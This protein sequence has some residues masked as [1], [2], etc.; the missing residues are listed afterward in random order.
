MPCSGAVTSFALD[1]L[2]SVLQ[3]T[4]SERLSQS[5][6][7]SGTPPSF[8]STFILASF[9]LY[10]TSHLPDII[11]YTICFLDVFPLES[12][13]YSYIPASVLTAM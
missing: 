12:K 8:S 9:V 4:S 1:S 10:S 2:L 7:Q 13:L 5:P 3:V 6:Y 11:S